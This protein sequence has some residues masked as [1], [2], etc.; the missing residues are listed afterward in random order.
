MIG[1]PGATGFTAISYTVAAVLGIAN[2]GPITKIQT[3][4]KTFAKPGL[5]LLPKSSAFPLL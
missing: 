4:P 1:T 3:A 5:T 2:N